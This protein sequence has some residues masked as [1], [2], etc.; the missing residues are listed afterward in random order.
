M[1]RR[2]ELELIHPGE[3]LLED[4]LKPL[5][6]SIFSPTMICAWRVGEVGTGR[7]EPVVVLRARD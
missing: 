7:L 1:A 3:I 5:G 6:I 4:F 2:R